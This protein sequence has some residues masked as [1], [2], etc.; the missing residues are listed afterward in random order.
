MPHLARGLDRESS[1]EDAPWRRLVPPAEP[2]QID[3][4]HRELAQGSIDGGSHEHGRAGVALD[5]EHQ[6]LTVTLRQSADAL[7]KAPAAEQTEEEEIDPALE[8]AFEIGT[9]DT[10]ARPDGQAAR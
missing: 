10:V 6:I 4:V 9:P 2:E 7:G 5:R 8:G 1:I 3:M